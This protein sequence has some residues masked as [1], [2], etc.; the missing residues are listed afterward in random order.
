MS[1][2]SWI[3]CGW[4]QVRAIEK[5]ARKLLEENDYKKILFHNSY[6]Y[7]VV[8]YIGEVWMYKHHP[9]RCKYSCCWDTIY[10]NFSEKQYVGTL[11][12]K[13][14]CKKYWEDCLFTI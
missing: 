4:F 13:Y 3:F 6:N 11:P 14:K 8:E 2:I 1:I 7:L 9:I 12:E 5:A 10:K